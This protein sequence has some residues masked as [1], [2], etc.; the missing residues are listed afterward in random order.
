ML[1]QCQM[2]VGGFQ[3]C[4]LGNKVSFSLNAFF[5][6]AFTYNLAGPYYRL[7]TETR[8]LGFQIVVSLHTDSFFR[9][10]L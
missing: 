3:E 1:N 10:V 6:P 5:L 2:I 8:A 4:I 9:L 7:K